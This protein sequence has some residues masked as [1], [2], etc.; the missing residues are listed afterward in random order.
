[1]EGRAQAQE[2][3]DFFRAKIA[4]FENAYLDFTAPQIGVRESRRVVGEY[5]LTVDDVLG[6]R[7][8]VDGIARAAYSIDIHSPTDGTS[9][10]RRL[11]PGTSYEI[12]YRSLVPKG[13]RNLLIASRCISSTHE[14]HSSLRVMPIVMAIGQAAGTAAAMCAASGRTPK[15]V[16]AREL[17]KRLVAEGADLD[18][19][20]GSSKPA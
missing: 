19:E 7:K 9:D 6:A 10:I 11:K 20:P 2:L 3:V 8:F 14:A 4:G 15:R 18:R 12:P 5:V 16:N 13:V 1:M 17:R